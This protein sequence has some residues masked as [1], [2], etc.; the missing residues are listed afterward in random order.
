LFTQASEE[1]SCKWCD[2]GAACGPGAV[3]RARKKISD[4]TLKP[5]AEL[6]SHE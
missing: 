2:F 4:V 5:F 6:I 1:T 3:S